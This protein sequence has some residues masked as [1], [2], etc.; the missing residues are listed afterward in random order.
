MKRMLPWVE[1]RSLRTQRYNEGEGC[2]GC[3]G[4][5]ARLGGEGSEGGCTA[6]ARIVVIHRHTATQMRHWAGSAGSEE[7][8]QTGYHGDFST[9][10]EKKQNKTTP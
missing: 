7:K 8:L 10:V 9:S 3:V 1:G 2:P 6:R 5:T 4:V